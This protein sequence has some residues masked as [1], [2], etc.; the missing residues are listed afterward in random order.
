MQEFN[1]LKLEELINQT[2]E[3]KEFEVAERKLTNFLKTF[4]CGLN[5]DVENF[6]HNISIRNEKEHKSRTYLLVNDSSN[7][8]AYFSIAIKPII[9]D[10]NKHKITNTTRK[11]M[12]SQMVKK[13]ENEHE[14]ITTFLIGQIAR[15]D[16]FSK[17]DISLKEI[18]DQVFY[19][20]NEVMRIIGGHIILIEVD[21]N[22]KLIN[23]Y[24]SFGFQ[25]LADGSED[26]L[27]QLMK[28]SGR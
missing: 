6:L 10:E 23:L 24:K 21:N 28:F 20:I 14:I 18:L 26:D 1:I 5:E 7:I 25:L 17:I 3:S 22:E 27:T 15:N 9:L 4:K 12:K 13:L 2:K 8:M 16:L 19:K 11:R